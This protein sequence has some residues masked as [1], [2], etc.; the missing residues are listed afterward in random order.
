MET[1]ALEQVRAD[2]CREPMSSPEVAALPASAAVGLP[3]AT[4]VPDLVGSVDATTVTE[5]TP[6]MDPAITRDPEPAP[7]AGPVPE[8]APVPAPASA[9]VTNAPPAVPAKFAAAAEALRTFRLQVP[10]ITASLALPQA[11]PSSF[12]V[13]PSVSTPAPRIVAR[14]STIPRRSPSNAAQPTP[15]LPD[16]D[17]GAMLRA[18]EAV[19]RLSRRLRG[20]N[21]G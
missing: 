1:P 20:P 13:A 9:P 18:S 6:P 5:S 15:I 2:E 12:P 21:V 10:P 4:A 14:T 3:A 17:A 8:P 7:T 19:G 16:V 11:K